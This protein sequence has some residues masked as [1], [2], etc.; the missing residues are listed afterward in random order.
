MKTLIKTLLL[1]GLLSFAASFAMAQSAV[2][3]ALIAEVLSTLK[4]DTAVYAIE[5][6]SDGFTEQDLSGTEIN[7]KPLYHITP[8]GRFTVQATIVKNGATVESKQVRLFIHKYANVAVVNDRIS[9]FAELNEKSV[10]IE[11]RDITDLREQPLVSI[12]EI[13][14][15]RARRNLIQGTIL[16]SGDIESIPVIKSHTD[17]HIIYASGLCRV[18]SQGQALQDGRI[19]DFIKIKNKSSGKIVFARVIDDKTAAVAP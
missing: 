5:I 1:I 17:I 4:L 14:G 11:K 3:D 18:T 19:G 13:K 12:E 16:T 6:L 9:R 15:N 7:I 8:L 10:S 2:K